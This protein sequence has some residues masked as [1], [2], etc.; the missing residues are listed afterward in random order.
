MRLQISIAV[1]MSSALI[2]S[3]CQP[4]TDRQTV[5]DQE[6]NTLKESDE[7]AESP[8]NEYEKKL[9]R[10]LS[11]LRS[12]KVYNPSNM[13][14]GQAIIIEAALLG[15]WAAVYHDGDQLDLNAQQKRKRAEFKDLVSREQV[16]R[17]PVLRRAQAKVYDEAGWESDIDAATIGASSSTLKFTAGIFAANRNVQSGMNAVRETAD[18]LR[19]K[20]VM[21]EWYPGSE[22]QYYDLKP[23]ADGEVLRFGKSSWIR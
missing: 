1:L 4:P 17:F 3:G 7:A 6:A 23:P 16:K 18:I 22:Y 20:R 5:N 14:K 8:E 21:F 10:E 13:D 11:S 9:D 15:A 2:I 12:M 19:Y